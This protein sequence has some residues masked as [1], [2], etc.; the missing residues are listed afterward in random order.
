MGLKT[1]STAFSKSDVEVEGLDIFVVCGILSHHE[2]SIAS[3]FI[4]LIDRG[5]TMKCS[6]QAVRLWITV[7][8]GC[9][10]LGGCGG[11][12]SSSGD[13]AADTATASGVKAASA[14]GELT[15]SQPGELLDTVKA[16]IAER[17]KAGQG[18]G[19]GVPIDFL[20]MPVVSANLAA[21][22]VADS[23]AAP[24]KFSGS[25]IQEA[26]VDEDDLIKTDGNMIYSIAYRY[27][28][29]RATRSKPSCRPTN[30]DPMASPTRRPHSNCPKAMP[31]QESTW[32]RP[33]NELR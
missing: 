25:T 16:L 15:A 1:A 24:P 14:T 6:I 30:V 2:F 28:K 5:P 22:A 13:S 9:I 3:S 8:A 20:R 32:L 27:N 7:M 19:D 17:A 12:G 29:T 18:S 21:T 4:S 33:S 26:A 11:G 10:A 31:L 23:A